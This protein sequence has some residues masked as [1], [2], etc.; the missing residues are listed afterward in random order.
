MACYGEDEMSHYQTE[1]ELS[2][3]HL[4]LLLLQQLQGVSLAGAVARAVAVAVF[5]APINGGVEAPLETFNPC[6]PLAGF[7]GF[8]R[9]SIL[10][11]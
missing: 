2:V 8:H 1:S 4:S 5:Y 3:A 11:G 6:P 10:M 9:F 7:A